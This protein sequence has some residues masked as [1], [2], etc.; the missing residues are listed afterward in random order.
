M[1]RRVRGH[2][3]GRAAQAPEV[4]DKIARR[5]SEIES[6]RRAGFS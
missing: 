2:P 5:F 6:V 1:A 3:F 4:I